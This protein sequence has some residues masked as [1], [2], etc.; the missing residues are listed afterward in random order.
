[1]T[2]LDRIRYWGGWLLTASLFAGAA[3]LAI[4]AGP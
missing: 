2:A 1:M 4:G 3:A